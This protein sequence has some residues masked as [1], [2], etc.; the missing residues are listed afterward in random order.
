DRPGIRQGSVHDAADQ[1]LSVAR[2]Q[3]HHDRDGERIE[4]SGIV[5]PAARQDLAADAGGAAALSGDS[6]LVSNPWTILHPAPPAKMSSG[7]LV[8]D[9][10]E[11]I[12]QS[13]DSAEKSSD[14]SGSTLLR[15]DEDNVATAPAWHGTLLPKTDADVWLAAAFAEYERIVSLE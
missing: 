3:V 6:P 10:P 14:D 2:R 12:K 4:V 13:G 7:L 5:R 1:R 15:S 9:L 8:V 11:K